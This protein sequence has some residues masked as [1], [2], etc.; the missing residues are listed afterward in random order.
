M[1]GKADNHGGRLGDQFRD[2]ALLQF[3]NRYAKA[4]KGISAG[5]ANAV[6]ILVHAGCIK[7]I[8]VTDDCR[9]RYKHP[10]YMRNQHGEDHPRLKEDHARGLPQT[11][12]FPL[13]AHFTTK[14]TQL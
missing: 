3:V 14:R 10:R 11:L 2:A 8:Q 12:L 1:G 4:W 6:G 5:R 7:I 9:D 13:I